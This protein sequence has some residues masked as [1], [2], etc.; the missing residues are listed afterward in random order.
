MSFTS[1]QFLLFLPVVLLIYFI[2]PGRLRIS[3]LLLAS[4]GFY[5][6][7]KPVYLLVLLFVTGVSYLAALQLD[8]FGKETAGQQKNQ[9]TKW[10]LLT[11]VVILSAILILFKYAGAFSVSLVIPVGISYFTFQIISYLV[12][13]YQGKTGAEKNFINYAFYVAFFPKIISGPI[14]RAE[15][16]LTQVRACSSRKLWNGEQVRDG[17]ALI[18][19]GFFQKLVIADRLAVFTGEI[20]GDYQSF[21][22]VELWIGAI[23]FYI[24]LYTDFAGCID[25]ARGMAKIMGFTLSENF[26]APFFAKSIREYWSRWHIS[27]S[28]WLR[29]YIYIPLG[30]SRQGTGR[31]YVNLLITFFISGAWHGSSWNFVLWGILH[32]V[33]QIAEYVTAP[34]I[35]KINAGLHTKT[36]SFSYKLM[37]TVKCWLLV[38]IA[39]IFFKVP[40]AMDGLRY[41]KRMITSWNPW[42]L[43]DGS[44]YTHGVS[45]RYFEVLVIAVLV[46]LLV[47]W[48]KYK[49]S[50]EIDTWLSQQC[51][52]F[53]WGTMLMLLMAVIILGAYG[54][55]YEA[56]NFIYFQF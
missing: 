25:M 30:G 40:T 33:Y 42:V 3:W 47:D 7:F 21:G 26:R 27:L 28:T 44:L 10:L 54:P 56:A 34:W 22:S 29:D 14:E 23:A 18:L 17:L 31:K 48:I 24:Q 35:D 37:Q 43:F 36:N 6:K 46:L 8:K 2:I 11:T 49:K 15:S 9:K 32:A 41:L 5:A 53:R 19:W 51:I 55:A 50:M 52:W 39:Y 20:F 4:W 16:F 12:D 38:C 1:L 13:V 45:E